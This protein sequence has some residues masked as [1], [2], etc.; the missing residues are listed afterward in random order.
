MKRGRNADETKDGNRTALSAVRGLVETQSRRS[1]TVRQMQKPILENG[2]KTLKKT[3]LAH[4]IALDPTVKQANA[5]ARAAGCA[6]FA[7]NWG[8]AEWERQYKAGLNPTK[9]KIKRDFNAIKGTQFSWIYDS[10]K[11]A[12]QGALNDLGQAFSNFFGSCKATRKGRKM[13][14]P[15]FRRKGQNDSFYVSNDMFSFHKVEALV[16]LP[17]IGPIR[18]RE[19]LRLKGRILS[20]RV[21]HRAGR[22][23]L[24]VQVEGGFSRESMP[25]RPI[26]GVD[27]GLK[28]A[29]VTSE[30][31]MIEAPKPLGAALAKLCR[32]NRI[33]HRRKKGSRN[34]K[35]AT[36]RLARIHQRVANIRR[37]FMQKVTTKLCCE[38]QAVVIEDLNVAGMLRNHRLARAM[39]DVGFGMFRRFLEYKGPLFGCQIVVAD[40][41]FP[42]SKR[43]SSCG[44]VKQTLALS[45]REYVC[46]ECGVV[47]DRDI[48]AALNLATY[49]WLTGNATPMKRPADTPVWA[50]GLAEVG[51]KPCLLAGTL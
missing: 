4:V 50:S 41:W 28:T 15:R 35:K 1:Q 11:D 7:Y 33:L 25:I 12:N 8:L 9:A 13:G 16:R 6:R 2:E 51:T 21:R 17:V 34:R 48:N 29:V 49:P 40:R 36:I 46:E 24:A 42:S 47:E 32:A 23:Y 31:E 3:M 30:G 27:L 26:I 5:L 10:P 44:N 14:Y 43:C 19:R 38:N 22:W 45:D 37:D 18:I 39:S 20:G